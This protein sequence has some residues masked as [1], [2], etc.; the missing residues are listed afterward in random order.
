MCLIDLAGS[1]RT[2][3]TNSKGVRFREG[4]NISRSLLALGNIINALAEPKISFYTI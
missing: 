1:E 4:A 2:C 3:A